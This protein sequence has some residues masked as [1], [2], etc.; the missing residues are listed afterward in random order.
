MKCPSCGAEMPEGR[1]YCEHCGQDIHVVPDF[2]PALEQQISQSMQEIL[3]GLSEK[4]EELENA[5]E[6]STI[7]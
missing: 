3:A 2:D 1:L 6:D 4:T 7:P 5:G